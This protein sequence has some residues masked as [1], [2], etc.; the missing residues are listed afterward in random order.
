MFEQT[1]VGGAP[2]VLVPRNSDRGHNVGIELETRAALT[3]F[4]GRLQGLFVNGNA[5][6]INSEVRLKPQ[7]SELVTTQHPLQGQATYLV[8]VG[9][10]YTA[11]NARVDGSILVGAVGRR[12]HSLAHHPLPDIYEQP[13]HSLDVVMNW[14]PIRRARIKLAAKNLLDPRIRQLQG[15][16]EVS[17]YRAGRAYSIAFSLGS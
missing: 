4:W 13:T 5:S 6:F 10:T 1:I 12:L 14:V 7:A 3:R 15:L 16:R 11:R 9:L 8:N 17:S 2:P